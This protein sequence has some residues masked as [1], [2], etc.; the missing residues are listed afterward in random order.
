[1]ISRSHP[2]STRPSSCLPVVASVRQRDIGQRQIRTRAHGDM[3]RI[4]PGIRQVG[5]SLSSR[6]ANN[7][8][9]A[10]HRVVGSFQHVGRPH[11]ARDEIARCQQ[12]TH[13][14]IRTRI[15]NKWYVI[16][17]VTASPF[18]NISTDSVDLCR[19]TE[20]AA[21]VSNDQVVPKS[22]STLCHMT[23]IM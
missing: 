22:F 6:G 10:H 19:R 2:T 23:S 8:C 13:L 11:L 18:R 15:Y 20:F 5:A 16:I 17:M 12:W 4:L 3:A 14:R 1:M 21:G 7:S 9:I